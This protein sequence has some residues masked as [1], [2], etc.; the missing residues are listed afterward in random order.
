[1]DSLIRRPS[2]LPLQGGR[3]VAIRFMLSDGAALTALLNLLGSVQVSVPAND[4]QQ[5]LAY[6]VWAGSLEELDRA[7]RRVG[8]VGLAL[9]GVLKEEDLEG[10]PQPAVPSWRVAVRFEV[11]NSPLFVYLTSVL[12]SLKV[13]P[14]PYGD[15]LWI[16]GTFTGSLDH[17]QGALRQLQAAD[18]RIL[19]EREVP[20]TAITETVVRSVTV[21]EGHNAVPA[22]TA[23]APTEQRPLPRPRVSAPPGKSTYW[24]PALV[25]VLLFVVVVTLAVFPA[26]QI[27]S[28]LSPAPPAPTPVPVV[29]PNTVPWSYL[30]HRTN[31]SAWFG[32][33]RN[34]GLSHEQMQELLTTLGGYYANRPALVH[35]ALALL[36][37]Q[38]VRT[39]EQFSTFAKS[40]GHRYEAGWSFPDEPATAAGGSGNWGI[41]RFYGDLSKHEEALAKILKFVGA[42]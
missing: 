31:A 5:G 22:L 29:D 2:G 18:L 20:T 9:V 19:N 7:L 27:Q 6:G 38:K 12:A 11:N 17:L 37:S 33:Q 3:R 15:E 24:L 10:P 25:G 14:E 23:P 32:W 34:E 30:V 1:M 39:P 26:K 8:V 16:E 42:A 4:P 35:R 41:I 40:L 28:L 13:T 21:T 36:R